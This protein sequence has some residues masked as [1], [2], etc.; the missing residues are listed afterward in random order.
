MPEDRAAV[1]RARV[2]GKSLQGILF[3]IFLVALIVKRI[4]ICQ[5][6]QR[7]YST[8]V[9]WRPSPT[10][11]C[12]SDTRVSPIPLYS[13]KQGSPPSGSCGN[14]NFSDSNPW[15]TLSPPQ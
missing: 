12:V 1:M 11:F 14:A 7:A 13:Y 8:L 2:I 6:I 5:I 15:F 9:P 4:V 10:A 3:P